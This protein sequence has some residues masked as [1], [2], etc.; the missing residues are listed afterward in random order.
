MGF[1]G[2]CMGRI[3]YVGSAGGAN[4]NIVERPAIV[5]WVHDQEKGVVTLTVF[6][7]VSLWFATE[8]EPCEDPNVAQ[9][10]RWRFPLKVL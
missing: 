10:N 6:G 7:G 3:V 5:Q 8:I 1:P 4:G 9:R 2:L